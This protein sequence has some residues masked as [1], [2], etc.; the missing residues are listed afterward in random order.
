M[1]HWEVCRKGALG[2]PLQDPSSNG[3]LASV[4]LAPEA[5][6][7]SV[8]LDL[9]ADSPDGLAMATELQTLLAEMD[10]E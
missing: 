2:E 10:W 5:L 6:D 1:L 3:D 8:D 7:T 9:N 4:P